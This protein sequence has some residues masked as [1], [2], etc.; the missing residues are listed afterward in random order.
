MLFSYVTDWEEQIF[1][2]PIYFDEPIPLDICIDPR[3]G[4]KMTYSTQSIEDW[5]KLKRLMQFLKTTQDDV[6]TLQANGTSVIKWY[7]D[8]ATLLSL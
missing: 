1:D 7:L 2:E 8:A 6:L 5:I 4:K 3:T